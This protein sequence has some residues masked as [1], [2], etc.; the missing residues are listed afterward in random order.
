M[1]YFI[2]AEVTWGYASE[3]KVHMDSSRVLSA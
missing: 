2:N 1:R 3:T